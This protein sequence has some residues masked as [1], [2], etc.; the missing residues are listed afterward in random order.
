M[1][2]LR[3]LHVSA[4][5][6]NQLLFLPLLFWL[7]FPQGICCFSQM[8]TSS[9][10]AF[11]LLRRNKQVCFS[12]LCFLLVANAKHGFASLFESFGKMLLLLVL[13]SLLAF[14]VVHSEEI[15]QQLAACL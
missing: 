11:M 7:L 14:L 4:S 15:Y 9:S 6:N 13:A 12:F 3:C 8:Y 1:R 2:S 10:E 5:P